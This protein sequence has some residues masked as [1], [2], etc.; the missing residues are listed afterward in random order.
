MSQFRSLCNFNALK[1]VSLQL[2]YHMSSQFAGVAVALEKGLYAKRGIDLNILPLCP[3]G[4]EVEKVLA[5]ATA[6]VRA[7]PS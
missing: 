5:L 3:P 2:D 7:L 1:R 6:E 4:A